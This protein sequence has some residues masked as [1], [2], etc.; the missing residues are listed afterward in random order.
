MAVEG[1][2][3]FFRRRPCRMQMTEWK[4]LKREVLEVKFQVRVQI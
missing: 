3:L 1:I 4:L 2:G